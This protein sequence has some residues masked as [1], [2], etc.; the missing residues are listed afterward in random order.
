MDAREVQGN[1]VFKLIEMLSLLLDSK[2]L[3]LSLSIFHLSPLSLPIYF[4]SSFAYDKREALS[5]S[6]FQSGVRN[7]DARISE[8]LR[9]K[10]KIYCQI[11]SIL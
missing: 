2:V 9:E 10:G 8:S 11:Y 1:V 5:I 3:P 6:C 4:F 7:R